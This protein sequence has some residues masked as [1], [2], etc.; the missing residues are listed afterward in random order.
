MTGALLKDV[1]EM[2]DRLMEVA[3]ATRAVATEV[4]LSRTSD[5]R[6][7]SGQASAGAQFTCFNGTKVQILTQQASAGHSRAF[8][9]TKVLEAPALLVPKYHKY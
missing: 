6:L 9:S 2:K 4:A 1:T 5:H 7:S 3:K 8:T